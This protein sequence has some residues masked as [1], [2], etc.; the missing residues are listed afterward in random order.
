MLISNFYH[1]EKRKDFQPTTQ[2]F[3]H[4]FSLEIIIISSIIIVNIDAQLV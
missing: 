4:L 3:F 1:Y 2:T